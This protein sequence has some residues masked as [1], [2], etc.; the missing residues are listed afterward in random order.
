MVRFKGSFRCQLIIDSWLPVHDPGSGSGCRCTIHDISFD[1]W[2]MC[3]TPS[4]RQT[5]DETLPFVRYVC[6]GRLSYGGNEA[7]C[8]I[9]IKGER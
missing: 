5:D 8:F 9:Q 3:E 2:P 6:Q 7:R 1:R 4:K